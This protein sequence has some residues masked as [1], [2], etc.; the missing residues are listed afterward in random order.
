MKSHRYGSR[1]TRIEANRVVEA[2]GRV[3]RDARYAKGISQ[4]ELSLRADVD[5]SFVSLME[6]GTHQPSLTTLCKLARALGM[7]PSTLVA[8]MERLLR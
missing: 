1:Q 6:R 2:F 5:R 8:R 7:A 4:S 3:L